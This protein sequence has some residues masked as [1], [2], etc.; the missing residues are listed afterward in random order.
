MHALDSF[1]KE[2]QRCN[3][4]NASSLERIALKPFTFTNGLHLPE[5][6]WIGTPHSPLFQGEAY[7]P[8]PSDFDPRRHARMRDSPDPQVRRQSP[9]TATSDHSMHF[10]HGR[11]TCP[12][13]H[14]A[15]DEVKLVMAHLLLS[16]DF[17]LFGPRPENMRLLK[18]NVP[19]MTARIWLRQ[20]KQCRKQS[21]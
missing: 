11:H 21:G 12:G 17:A 14:M 10:G 9:I 19:N 13:R 16:Y 8:N 5:G 2:T 4:L 3:V 20:R 7:Y 15:S 6:T 18:F 1:I